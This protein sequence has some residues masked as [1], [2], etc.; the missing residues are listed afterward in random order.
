MRFDRELG[1]SALSAKGLRVVETYT[2]SKAYSVPGWRVGALLGDAEVVSRVARIKSHIDYGLHLPVQLAAAAGLEC[3]ESLV[4]T[5]VE[6]YQRRIVVLVEGLSQAGWEL[7]AP[8]AGVCVWA[9]LPDRVDGTA[10]DYCR[11]M[12]DRHG[13]VALPGDLFGKD[14]A[15]FV[16]FAAVVSQESMYEVLEGIT[17]D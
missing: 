5:A 8:Q 10:F 9:K 7:S 11:R 1:P 14:F 16:R 15:R 2:M 6:A 3:T 13:V 17:N 12:L 4:E